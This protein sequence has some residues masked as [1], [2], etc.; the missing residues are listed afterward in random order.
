MTVFI[1]EN[2]DFVGEHEIRVHVAYKQIYW[3]LFPSL[4]QS[5]NQTFSFIAM[6]GL[7]MISFSLIQER[8]VVVCEE[9]DG[10]ENAMSGMELS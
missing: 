1:N 6:N 4:Q 7:C 5:S 8:N 9:E 2:A 3:P 10:W